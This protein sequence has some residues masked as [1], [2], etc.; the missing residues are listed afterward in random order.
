[1]IGSREIEIEGESRVDIGVPWKGQIDFSY[2]GFLHHCLLSSP[3]SAFFR[4]SAQY[5]CKYL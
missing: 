3:I 2:E 1:M 5:F 4:E